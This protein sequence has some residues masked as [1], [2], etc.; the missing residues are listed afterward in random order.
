MNTFTTFYG[1]GLDCIPKK[2]LAVIKH[3][4]IKSLAY[5]TPPFP[6]TLYWQCAEWYYKPKIIYANFP[7]YTAN[8]PLSRT[9][10]QNSW[11]K[12]KFGSVAH[13]ED[14]GYISS[15]IPKSFGFLCLYYGFWPH[16]LAWCTLFIVS[17]KMLSSLLLLYNGESDWMSIQ[18]IE[19]PDR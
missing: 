14:S 17:K 7:R 3:D 6:C 1:K 15:K 2:P 10:D 5:F 12:R 4:F 8:L 18:P 16:F 9:G 19:V 13:K 11:I